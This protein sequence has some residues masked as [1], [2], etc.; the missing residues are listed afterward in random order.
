MIFK[1]CPHFLLLTEEATISF[2][3]STVNRPTISIACDRF[4]LFVSAEGVTP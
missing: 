2:G 3:P 4:S 1:A